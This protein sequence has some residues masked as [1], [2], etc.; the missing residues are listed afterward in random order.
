MRKSQTVSDADTTAIEDAFESKTSTEPVST[1]PETKEVQAAVEPSTA[2]ISNVKVGERE[3]TPDELA[4]LVEKAERVAS[5]E[6]E[7]NVDIEQLYPDYTRKSQLLNDPVKLGGYISEKFGGTKVLT[8]EEDSRQKA[9]KEARE[10]YGIVTKEDLDTFK[11]SLKEEIKREAEVDDLLSVAGEI[12]KEKGINK[13]DLF[14]FMSAT[15]ETNPQV[16]ADKIAEYRKVNLGPVPV[17]PAP[18]F[19]ERSGSSGT[20]IPQEKKLPSLNDHDAMSQ[21]IE[22]MLQTPGP[23]AEI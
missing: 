20:H 13:K 19:T 3:F 14:D 21:V 15:R 22:D 2:T 16:A 9:I 10:M 4:K 17:K 12:E 23:E 6:K 1:E 18:T 5:I 11:Q 7:Q 8:P